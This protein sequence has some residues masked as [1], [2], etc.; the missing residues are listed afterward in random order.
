MWYNADLMVVYIY[1]SRWNGEVGGMKVLDDL[2][3]CYISFS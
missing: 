3:A 2:S 1:I